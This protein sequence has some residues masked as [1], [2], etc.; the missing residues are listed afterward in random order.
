MQIAAYCDFDTEIVRPRQLIVILQ[1]H[2]YEKDVVYFPVAGP[3]VPFEAEDF[4]EELWV[5]VLL[6]D[7][8]RPQSG[9]GILG[10]HLAGILER[11]GIEV[12]NLVIQFDDIEEVLQYRP[13]R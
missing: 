5:S 11:H 3:F 10:V 2:D 7:L 9:Q 12:L 8:V 13:R 1:H 4:S 6:E